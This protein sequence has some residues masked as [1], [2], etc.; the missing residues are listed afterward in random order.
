VILLNA[1]GTRFGI[2]ECFEDGQHVPAVFDHASEDAAQHGFALGFTMPFEQDR[3][4]DFDIAAKFRSRVPTQ[5]QAVE[6]GRLPLGEVE[7]VLRLFGPW[8]R[9]LDRRVGF[10]LH[11][12]YE[13]GQFT[14]SFSRVK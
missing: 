1:L 7:I 6:E 11:R 4:G 2:H 10:S 13:K 3:L 5:E 12:S 8:G 9:G 14:R